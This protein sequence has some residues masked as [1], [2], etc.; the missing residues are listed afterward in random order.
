MA[1]E[2]K[3]N[4]KELDQETGMYYYGARYYIPELSIWGSVDPLADQRS[5][6]SPYSYCQNNPVM[7]VDPTGALDDEYQFSE[8]GKYLGKVK[9][10]GEHY[11]AIISN[12]GKKTTFAFADP[13]NDPKSIDNKD[14][15]K[16][17]FPSYKSIFD[18]LDRAGVN[19]DENRGI[20]DGLFYL[21]NN[22]NSALDEGPLDFTTKS[23]I[24]K[25]FEGLPDNYLYLTSVNGK[26]V[27]HNYKNFGN[28]LWGASANALK[29]SLPDALLGA[30][31]NNFFTDVE[32]IGKKWSQRSFDSKDD[33]YSI[34]LGWNWMNNNKR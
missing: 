29:V 17:Y 31:V 30:H 22:S 24:I 32:N 23:K 2:Y 5:W 4:G 3:F 8:S 1:T 10:E 13:I 34:R 20:I 14:I 6:V 7:R 16:L 27:S 15:N 12:D 19:K 26:L 11:G 33:Q 25:G 21:K 28:F 18:D 9:K